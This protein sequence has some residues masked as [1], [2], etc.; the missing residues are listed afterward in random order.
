MMCKRDEGLMR[1]NCGSETILTHETANRAQSNNMSERA[2][3][4]DIQG[5]PT[6][7]LITTN[8]GVRG[9]LTKL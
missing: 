8:I 1:V 3:T 6:H 7:L 4:A 9:N 5:Q 2:Q